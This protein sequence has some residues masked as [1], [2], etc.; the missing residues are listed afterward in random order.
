[1]QE[2]GASGAWCR[3]GR[4][5]M[6]ECQS[7][8]LL[9]F[10]LS[11]PRTFHHP[12]E[13]FLL[14]TTPFYPQDNRSTGVYTQI[15]RILFPFSNSLKHLSTLQDTIALGQC[16]AAAPIHPASS[17]F[18][19]PFFPWGQLAHTICRGS[20]DTAMLTPHQTS[21]PGPRS[22]RCTSYSLCTQLSVLGSLQGTHYTTHDFDM[23]GLTPRAG[24]CTQLGLLHTHAP[25]EAFLCRKTPKQDGG[26]WP[27][28]VTASCPSAVPMGTP[29]QAYLTPPP[30][31]Q[32]LYN[33]FQ[34][35]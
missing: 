23:T 8:G 29:T 10:S 18:R 33:V 28:D 19:Q 31:C 30:W 13:G 7:T 25:A 9:F 34:V 21:R 6:G 17:I 11:L 14:S 3:A 1:M 20:V 26:A 32:K 24:S 35:K 4:A 5:L 22:P 15:P 2:L 16:L 27:A 12:A